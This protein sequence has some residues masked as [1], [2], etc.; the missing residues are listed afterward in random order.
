MG[1]FTKKLGAYKKYIIIFLCCLGSNFSGFG[2]IY[3]ISP[4]GDGGFET[5]AT[6]ANNNWTAVNQTNAWVIG[7]T[8]TG[9]TGSRGVF[10]SDNSGTNYRYA[11][12]T[13]ST[14]HLYYSVTIPA[15][16]TSVNLSFD[17]NSAGEASNW[18]QLLVFL[19]STTPTA[20]TPSGN[21][22]TMSGS[23]NVFTQ[24]SITTYASNYTNVT[25]NSIS[26]VAGQTYYLIF[27]WKND[28]A[29]A[30]QPPAAVDNVSLSYY[31]VILI[32]RKLKI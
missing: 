16:V 7:T 17:L 10:I 9:Y 11:T 12:G 31:P 22:T 6:L 23:S 24:S 5:G 30:T 29:T 13:A 20:G 26:V 15:G 32:I 18:D 3:L 14:S 8:A 21:T 19:G 25:N 27:T 28:A 1:K 2:Q 4:T